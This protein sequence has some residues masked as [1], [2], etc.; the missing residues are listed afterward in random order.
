MKQNKIKHFEKIDIKNTGIRIKHLRKDQNLT[1]EVL[2]EMAG[3][4]PHYLYEIESGRKSMS[5]HILASLACALQVS[6]DYLLFGNESHLFDVDI[7]SEH[8]QL[9]ELTTRLTSSQKKHVLDI[10]EVM[11]PY[12]KRD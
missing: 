10:L 5:I 12:L 11:I 2:S 6:V 3:I 8:K 4:T 7:P 9:I 1:Q